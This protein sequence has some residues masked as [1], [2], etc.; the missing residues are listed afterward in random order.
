[1]TRVTNNTSFSPDCGGQDDVDKKSSW[2]L[3]IFHLFFLVFGFSVGVSNVC[4]PHSLL[5]I[6][7]WIK[8]QF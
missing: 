8:K 4:L 2:L 5:F 1:M 7:L 3:G 6:L